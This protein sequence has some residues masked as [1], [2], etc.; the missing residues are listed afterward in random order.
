MSA[1]D[2]MTGID[3]SEEVDMTDITLRTV[4]ELVDDIAADMAELET[5]VAKENVSFDKVVIL[6]K[7]AELDAKIRAISPAIAPAATTPAVVNK[8]AKVRK[9]SIKKGEGPSFILKLLK[10]QPENKMDKKSLI[11][12]ARSTLSNP[13]VTLNAL[14]HRSPPLIAVIEQDD[15]SYVRLTKEGEEAAGKVCDS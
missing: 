1:N 3:H 14:E 12:A 2:L 5:A 6:Q 15:K 9:T 10:Q 11:A 4:S 8:E 7:L 13:Y